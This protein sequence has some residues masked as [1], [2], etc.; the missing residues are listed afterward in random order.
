MPEVD[1]K[2]LG[3][4]VRGPRRQELALDSKVLEPERDNKSALVPEHMLQLVQGML[5][6]KLEHV[7]NS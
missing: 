1:N 5:V 2:V 4:K 7:G 3:N 6:D